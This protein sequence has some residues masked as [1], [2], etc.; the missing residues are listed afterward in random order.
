M[1]LYL[2]NR[3]CLQL[4]QVVHPEAY[5]FLTIPPS[6]FSTGFAWILACQ[7]HH[8]HRP[9]NQAALA[10]S[11]SSPAYICI[12][13]WPFCPRQIPIGHIDCISHEIHCRIDSPLLPGATTSWSI[14]TASLVESDQRFALPGP[15]VPRPDGNTFS[16]SMSL[17]LARLEGGSMRQEMDRLEGQVFSVQHLCFPL[18]LFT[19]KKIGFILY[20]GVFQ[21]QQIESSVI[22]MWLLH[23]LKMILLHS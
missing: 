9:L 3:W 5:R 7:I 14:F 11:P 13:W 23:A 16:L 21:S 20:W 18:E 8:L 1:V 10:S 12:F 22:S 19:Q 6:T 15:T 4:F 17:T 2:Q